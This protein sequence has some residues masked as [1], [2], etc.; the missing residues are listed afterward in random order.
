MLKQLQVKMDS[1][2]AMTTMGLHHGVVMAVDGIYGNYLKEIKMALEEIRLDQWLNLIWII[3]ILIKKL[4]T[5][6]A[7]LLKRME[8]LKYLMDLDGL[9]TLLD[10]LHL[11]EL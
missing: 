9:N 5:R 10:L 11:K 3:K 6:L 4:N 1:Y 7:I 8:N 2:Q